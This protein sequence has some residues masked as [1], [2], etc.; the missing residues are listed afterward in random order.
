VMAE[1]T[2]QAERLAST[3]TENMADEIP[4]RATVSVDAYL[5]PN[6]APYIQSGAVNFEDQA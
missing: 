3:M 6:Q 4:S 5:T 2:E 1:S